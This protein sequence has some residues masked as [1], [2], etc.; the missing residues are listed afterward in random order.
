MKDQLPFPEFKLGLT[1]FNSPPLTKAFFAGKLVVVDFWTY[2]CINCL[3]TL[4]LLKKLEKKYHNKPVFFL[5]IHSAK[6]PNE[7]IDEQIKKAIE[8]YTITHA[9]VNDPDLHTW[10]ILGVRA[11]PTLLLLGPHEN[12]LFMASGEGKIGELDLMIEA[13][14]S[15]YSLNAIEPAPPF[16]EK[17]TPSFLSFPGKVAFN[18]QRRLI[19]IADSGHN[20]LVLAKFDGTVV[21]IIGGDV[22]GFHDGN[23]PLAK[24]RSPQGIAFHENT[25]YVADTGNHALRCID[26]DQQ[27][28]QTIAGIG[29]QGSD[30]RGGKIGVKQ[31]LNS[32]WDVLVIANCLFIAMAG[33]HQIWVYDVLNKIVTNFSGSGQELHLNSEDALSAAWAQPSGLSLGK[34]FLYVADSESSSIRRIDLTKG[35]TETVIG[36]DPQNSSNL[37]VFGDCEGGKEKALLQHPLAVLYL[38]SSRELVIADTYNH[39]LKKFHLKSGQLKNWVGKGVAGYQDGKKMEACFD[40]PSGLAYSKADHCVLVADTNN[41]AIR[42]INCLT[43]EV[44]TLP[45][46]AQ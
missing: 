32:P 22:P 31:A 41:H 19:C 2:C 20:R 4:P 11:W 29:Q 9:V 24:F 17:A 13:A 26:F 15:Y 30:R 27:T 8:R 16:L 6:F 40:E 25:L 44:T 10:K 42:V 33:A 18:A 14:L 7:K 1:W 12:C 34:N 21:E 45:L 38:E 37:F 23:F 28:V 36:G 3:H 43:N 39:R 46:H 35:S 5:G